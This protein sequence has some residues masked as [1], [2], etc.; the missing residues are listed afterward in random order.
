MHV[1]ALH[2]LD[3]DASADTLF[4]AIGRHL[5]SRLSASPVFTRRLRTLPLAIANPVWI[6][7]SPDLSHHFQRVRLPAPGTRRQL[8]AVVS[9]LHGQR[10]DRRRPLWQFVLIDGLEDGGCAFY[11]KVHHA[12]IDGAAGVALAYALLDDSPVAAYDPA[13]LLNRLL[14]RM[15]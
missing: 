4:E 7:A 15:R 1:G 8:D 9:R 2:L 10:L 3:A 6:D 14:A 11:T 13:G 5:K 12:A